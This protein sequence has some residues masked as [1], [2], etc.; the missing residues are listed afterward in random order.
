ML[1]KGTII[2]LILV[3][4]TGGYILKFEK[5]EAELEAYRAVDSQAIRFNADSLSSIAVAKG[6]VK[7]KVV[8]DAGK[9]SLSE[10]VEA[11]VSAEKMDQLVSRIGMLRRMDVIPVK[12]EK[13]LKEYGFDEPRAR[14]TLSDNQGTKTWLIGRDTPI[15][16]T[17][18]YV[19]EEGAEEAVVANSFK[20]CRKH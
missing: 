16:E 19:M 18:L 13:A 4:I 14:L 10:P 15:G 6:E 1:S 17:M 5:S 20:I 7:F 8:R 3:I 11:K 2:L 9:W 12:T